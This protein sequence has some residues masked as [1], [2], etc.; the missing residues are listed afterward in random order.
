M[1]LPDARPALA[2]E[3]A[4]E[5]D[6]LTVSIGSKYRALWRC[7]KCGHEWR[8]AVKNRSTVGT[9]CPACA[10]RALIVGVNDLA[11]TDPDI[12]AQLDD[13][14][15][16]ATEL[17][18]GTRRVVRWWCPKGHHWQASVLNRTSAR[19]GCG[20]CANRQIVPGL[21]DMATV[22]PELAAEL[23][24]PNFT[25]D[26]LNAGSSKKL[27][28]RCVLG[29]RWVATAAARLQQG[30]GCPVCA[31][32]TVLA[33]FNDLATTH[34]AL[35]VEWVDLNRKPTEVTRGS[36]Y[37]AR[38]RCSSGHEWE[39][40]VSDRACLGAGCDACYGNR[41]VSRFED[42]VYAFL[43]AA[44]EDVPVERTVRRFK[45]DGISELD[46]FIPSLNIAIECHGVYWHSE[47]F[48]PKGVHAA[49]RAACEALGIRLIQ[50]WEDDWADRRQVV[51]RMLAHKLGVST[52][53]R[54]AARATTA[55]T[56]TTAEA[57]EF[58]EA[59]HIQGFTVASHYLALE[60]DGRL[61]AL[62]SLKR[63]G[64][65]GELRLERYAT[66]AHV[67][68]GQSKLIRH[69]ERTIPGW[70]RLV[71]FADHEVSD[72]SLY[73]RTG[74]VKDGELAPDYKYRVGARR[75]HKFSYRLARFRSDPALKFEE[76]LSE[77]QLAQLNGLDRIWDSGKTRYLYAPSR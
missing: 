71:T 14:T 63:T 3:W 73:E 10:G 35:A 68:G 23:D 51:E 62:M 27:Q 9:G 46:I 67:L 77:R 19:S 25:A 36:S 16:S 13:P 44:I 17:T 15:V 2:A 28:W 59:N 22:A 38:W 7:A 40:A 47:R 43:D 4:D 30:Q 34:P 65:A 32:K 45:R 60:H 18:R 70:T 49:K 72:G 42:E 21:N 6:I 29:H 66:A 52:E 53:P 55:R 39:A 61:V 11:T 69:A 74:W 1:N 5:R 48:K 8:T 12:A 58:L 33:G 31:N 20:V 64:K 41:Y 75:E 24:D 50:V 57:R 37:R 26:Q 76:G 56:A 54:V